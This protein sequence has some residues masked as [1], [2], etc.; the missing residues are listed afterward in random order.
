MARPMPRLPPVTTTTFPANRWLMMSLP[1]WPSPAHEAA[2]DDEVDAGAER[3]RAADE[4][5]RRA[6]ELVD[7]GHAAE[8]RVAFEDLDL[9]GHLRAQGHRRG[10]GGPGGGV[11]ARPPGGP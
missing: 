11:F 5:H 8:R 1:G 2:V 3:G 7:R 10:G 6:D 9:L 4:E